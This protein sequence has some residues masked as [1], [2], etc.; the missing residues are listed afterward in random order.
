MVKKRV[1]SKRAELGKT[2]KKSEAAATA[3][4][5]EERQHKIKNGY[6]EHRPIFLLCQS[7]QEQQQEQEVSQRKTEKEEEKLHAREKREKQGAARS[8]IIFIP[9]F[10]AIT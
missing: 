1:R 4:A 7:Q 10:T 5:R 8:S 9:F 2:E 6:I 3:A